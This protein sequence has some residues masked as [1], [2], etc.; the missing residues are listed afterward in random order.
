MAKSSNNSQKVILENIK[1][2]LLE[3]GVETEQA[4]K[5]IKLQREVS[6]IKKKLQEYSQE[7]YQQIQIEQSASNI[8]ILP[9]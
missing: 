9:R 3:L 2:K 5:I 1:S 6:E 4:E 7:H 8:E